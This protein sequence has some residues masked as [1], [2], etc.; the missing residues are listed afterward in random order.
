MA[1]TNSINNIIQVD[2]RPVSEPAEDS[3]SNPRFDDIALAI[4]RTQT[5]A[6][7]RL[8]P[9]RVTAANPVDLLRN[10]IVRQ[11]FETR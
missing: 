4:H 7:K 10:L 1:D 6:S 11:L 5:S 3:L 2:F 9:E 8:N